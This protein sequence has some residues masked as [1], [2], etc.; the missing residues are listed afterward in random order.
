[1]FCSLLIPL[2]SHNPIPAMSLTFLRHL[3]YRVGRLLRRVR[4]RDRRDST[5]DHGGNRVQ[6]GQ[7]DEN[8]NALVLPDSFPPAPPSSPSPTKDVNS[9]GLD[10]A[11]PVVEYSSNLRRPPPQ[12]DSLG[13]MKLGRR[14]HSLPGQNCNLKKASQTMLV[15]QHTVASSSN[16][17]SEEYMPPSPDDPLPGGASKALLRGET[18]I[19]FTPTH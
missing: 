5:L 4:V 7:G 10:D 15:A 14:I 1:L 18:S 3:L 2:P 6:G 13:G 11:H 8:H 17:G 16:E 9:V 12:P 19:S